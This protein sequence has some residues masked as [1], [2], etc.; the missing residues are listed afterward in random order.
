MFGAHRTSR[1]AR[2]VIFMV[3]R[4]GHERQCA[5]IAA[6][7]GG[8]CERYALRG[9]NYCKAHQQGN[10]AGITVTDF[11]QSTRIDLG[12]DIDID[13]PPDWQAGRPHAMW[14]VTK[15]LSKGQLV[16]PTCCELCGKE[17]GYTRF[18]RYSPIFKR[19]L[20]VLRPKIVAH[21]ANG[22]DHPLDVWWICQHC[23]S[24]LRGYKYHCGLVTREQARMILG[25][26]LNTEAR[27]AGLVTQQHRV[28]GNKAQ[29]I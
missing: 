27:G 21:H 9:S 2:K 14:E 24:K 20:D 4:S 6:M 11:D 19:M 17:P 18:T 12:I 29:L 3:S 13:E 10:E 15:A 7:H 8:R 1:Q 26:V 16:R 23:N 22:Y 28:R 5:G 25:I